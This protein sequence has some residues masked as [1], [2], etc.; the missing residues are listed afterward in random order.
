ML[1]KLYR[2]MMLSVILHASE[3]WRFVLR[4]DHVGVKSADKDKLSVR[5]R[6]VTRDW[7][8]LRNAGL[9]MLHNDL[10]YHAFR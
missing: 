4:K 2:I 10:C 9:N 5:Q 7:R 8:K 3:N 6:K 1:R